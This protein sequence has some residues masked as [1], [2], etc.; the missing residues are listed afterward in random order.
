MGRRQR[1]RERRASQQQA[2]GSMADLAGLS[3]VATR[4]LEAMHTLLAREHTSLCDRM[5]DLSGNP[6]PGITDEQWEV[7]S[8]RFGEVGHMMDVLY[9]EIAR[10][11]GDLHLSSRA[12]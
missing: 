4:E 9:G 2:P 8:G 11:Y 1:A 3:S 6:R 7:M 5:A 10:R 12:P